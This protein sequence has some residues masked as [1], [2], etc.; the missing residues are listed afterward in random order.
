MSCATKEISKG[1]TVTNPGTVPATVTIGDFVFKNITVFNEADQNVKVS[2]K[3]TN[4]NAADFI[5]PKNGRA[6]TRSI[7]G[8]LLITSL[9]INAIGNAATGTVIFNLGN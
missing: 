4:G 1:Y 8:E 6:F 3:D 9:Q 5:V 2:Y 7:N